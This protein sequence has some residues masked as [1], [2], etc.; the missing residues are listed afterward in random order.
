[1][2]TDYFGEDYEE[3]K[4]WTLADIYKDL[5]CRTEIAKVLDVNPRR[6]VQ[7][8]Q[9]RQRTK[10]PK[11]LRAWGRFHLYSA[12]EWRVWYAA[13]QKKHAKRLAYY[14]IKPYGSG[15]PFFTFDRSDYDQY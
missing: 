10:C 12:E 8:I 4:I 5:I 3:P 2:T 15:E 9:R 14:D 7:W 13:F 11:P 1:M 6:V